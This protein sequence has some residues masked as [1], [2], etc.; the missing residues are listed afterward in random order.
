[1]NA[2]IA[3]TSTA[4][5]APKS[6][7]DVRSTKVAAWMGAIAGLLAVAVGVFALGYAAKQ[8][9]LG[10][11]QRSDASSLALGQF[12]LQLDQAFERHQAAHLNLRPGGQWYGMS[13]RPTDDEMPIAIAYMGLFERIKI[14]IDLKLLRPEIVNRLYG[15]RVGNI[16]V[17]DRIM[18]EKLVKL[19]DGWQDFLKLVRYME[20]ERNEEYVP[21][22]WA[23]YNGLLSQTKRI[24]VSGGAG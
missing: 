4:R 1:M 24:G 15:Y 17:N 2:T 8:V 16:W 14:M 9:K 11:E 19:S 22:R 13:D 3:F 20:K 6:A 18:R 5:L 21:G 12:L 23:E 7:Y 10:R